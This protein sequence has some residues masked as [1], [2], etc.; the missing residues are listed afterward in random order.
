MSAPAVIGQADA[1]LRSIDWN[2]TD[3]ARSMAARSN[4]NK[5]LPMPARFHNP[6][7]TVFGGGSLERIADLC[8]ARSPW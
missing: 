5:E 4:N 8:Q 7:A 2:E 1:H 3:E 6:V